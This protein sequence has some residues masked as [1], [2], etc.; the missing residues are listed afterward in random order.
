MTVQTGLERLANDGSSLLE[1]RR[2][3][4]LVNATS[5]DA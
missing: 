3:G 5:V 2:I 4:L 1:G